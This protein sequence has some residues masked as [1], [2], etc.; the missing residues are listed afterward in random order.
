[1]LTF[2]DISEWEF[3]Q[4]VLWT[5]LILSR[6]RLVSVEEENVGRNG[7]KGEEKHES[8]HVLQ[9]LEIK[10]HTDAKFFEIG[11]S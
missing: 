9:E 6:T 2:P 11:L 10:S 4:E 1:M 5:V 3:R 7:E 8:A